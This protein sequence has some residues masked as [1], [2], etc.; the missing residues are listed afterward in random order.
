MEVVVQV[1]GIALS[2]LDRLLA[3]PQHL[4][5]TAQV[6][7]ANAF[8]GEP[9]D[10]YLHR[11]PQ[12]VEVQQLLRL[13]G[14]DAGPPPRGEFEEPL[15]GDA[16]DRLPHRP[17]TDA[18]PGGNLYFVQTGSRG[19]GPVHDEVLQQ[20]LCLTADGLPR[21]EPQVPVH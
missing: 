19:E 3:L 17:A 9:G 8:G 5:D 16:L 7:S 10:M 12:L 20:V 21:F 4:L 15:G 11:L 6:L 1:G 14:P 18:E 13:E 2:T